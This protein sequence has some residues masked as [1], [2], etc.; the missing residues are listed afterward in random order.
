M[1]IL[2][3]TKYDTLAASS[4]LRAYQYK[5]KMDSSRFEV[6]VK[7]LLSNRYLER[8]FTNKRISIFY[9]AYLF[10]KRIFDLLNTDKYDVIIIHLELFPFIPPVF[11]WLLFKTNKK[12]YFDYDDAVYHN[13][14]MADNFLIRLFLG[15]KIKYLM[16]KADGVIAGNNYTEKYA[17]NSGAT[18][19]LI[20]PTVINIDDYADKAP[21]YASKK[22]FTI[23]WIGSPSTATYLEI[24]KEPLA[25]LGQITPVSLHLVGA[26]SNLNL[27]IDNVEVI[28]VGWSEENEQKALKEF[29]VGI[30][31]LYDRPWDKGKCAFKLI[32]YMASFLPVV[33]SNVGMNAEIINNRA[34]GL[35]A[36]S[37]D[38]W[39]DSLYKIYHDRDIRKVM[40]NNGRRLIETDFT[41]QSRLADFEAFISREIKLVET[42]D[43]DQELVTL[44]SYSLVTIGLNCASTIARTIDSVLR[45]TILPKQYVFVLGSSEDDSYNLILS[46]KSYI[47]EKGIEFVLLDEVKS[48]FAAIPSAWNLGIEMVNSDIVAILN[49]DDFYPSSETMLNVLGNFKKNND[50]LIVSGRIN[51]PNSSS[52]EIAINNM[53]EVIINTIGHKILFP[54]LNP[55]NHPAT[56]I[57]KKLYNKIG[58]YNINYVVSSDYEFLYRAFSLGYKTTINNEV[59][60][61]ME[62]GGFASQHKEIGRKEAY[63][64][65]TSYTKLNLLPGLAFILRFILRK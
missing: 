63:K 43:L 4:R 55:Y 38:D 24:V 37:S 52:F 57:S 41:I 40:G 10:F 39:F 59:L 50:C 45:Q 29:D 8:K 62:P 33:S 12:I 49:A 61:S 11:E 27:S 30:M 1:K 47:E 53:R 3:L 36:S 17:L 18:N 35:L 60:V 2:F 23:G 64:I 32:Q 34:N 26:G 65:A 46:Y 16:R 7:P 22:N 6:D 44:P 58:L 28:S 51:H 20:L 15:P 14:D 54:Y 19:I 21:A 25:K 31:P 13:Y 42:I 9:L 5:D 48:S 56:F